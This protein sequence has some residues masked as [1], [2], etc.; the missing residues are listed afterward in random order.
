MSHSCFCH[1]GRSGSSS[2][3]SSASRRRSLETVTPDPC[4]DP[5]GG[6][7]VGQHLQGVDDVLQ[8]NIR[9][10]GFETMI[11][12]A[13]SAVSPPPY[14]QKLVESLRPIVRFFSEVGHAKHPV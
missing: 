11:M 4:R 3:D 14:G 6:G 13:L 9:G 2:P 10:H 12:P 5:I 8:T 7:L 1:A